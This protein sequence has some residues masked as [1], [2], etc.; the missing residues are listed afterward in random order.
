[1]NHYKIIR[2]LN[3]E[4]NLTTQPETAQPEKR[5][6]VDPLT[7]IIWGILLVGFGLF[8]LISIY[9]NPQET[10][11]VLAAGPYAVLTVFGSIMA[12][13][14]IKEYNEEKRAR[15]PTGP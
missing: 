13:K 5:A 10:Q 12:A 11:K 2:H 8:F 15:T 9:L 7:F 6:G 14:G 1:M 3:E 4:M